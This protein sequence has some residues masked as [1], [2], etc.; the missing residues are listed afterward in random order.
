MPFNQINPH[1]DTTSLADQLTLIINMED[2]SQMESALD[3]LLAMV[4]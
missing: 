4:G 3:T 2:E 1:L